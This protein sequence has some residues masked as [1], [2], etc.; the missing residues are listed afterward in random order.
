MYIIYVNHQNMFLEHFDPS[1]RLL[2]IWGVLAWFGDIR[3]EVL[4]CK[5]HKLK[6]IC[7]IDK[8]WSWLYHLIHQGKWW[9]TKSCGDL[10]V[11]HRCSRLRRNG[12]IIWVLGTI[13]LLLEDRGCP[14]KS[15]RDLLWRDAHFSTS[16]PGVTRPVYF[17]PLIEQ[18]L[19]SMHIWSFKVMR[20]NWKMTHIFILK[21]DSPFTNEYM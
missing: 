8:K 18:T 9:A 10:H 2:K 11:L 14:G 1:F 15:E 13:L 3:D 16:E 21:T 20:F 19:Y 5:C 12:P 4:L 7:K 17:N 6:N